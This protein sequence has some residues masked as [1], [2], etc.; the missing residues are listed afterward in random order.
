ME[1][2]KKNITIPREFH[3]LFWEVDVDGIDLGKHANYV[4]ERFLEFGTLGGIRWLRSVYSDEDLRQ[5]VREKSYRFRSPKTLNF[6][7]LILNIP[8]NEWKPSPRFKE[9]S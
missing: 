6:W 7:R 9:I 1:N 2:R 3:S 4:I 8:Q 5:F